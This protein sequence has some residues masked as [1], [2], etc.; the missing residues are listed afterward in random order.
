VLDLYDDFLLDSKIRPFFEYID[1]DEKYVPDV[2]LFNE[3]AQIMRESDDLDLTVKN[4][5]KSNLKTS[6]SVHELLPFPLGI[7][8]EDMEDILTDDDFYAEYIL[9][10]DF[11]SDIKNNAHYKKRMHDYAIDSNVSWYVSENIPYM[12]SIF[13]GKVLFIA[14]DGRLK[15]AL[16]CNNDP[17]REWA[18]KIYDEIKESADELEIEHS[19]GD[20]NISRCE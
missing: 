10:A 8:K 4:H 16:E 12:M 14:D 7:R 5:Y 11:L 19:N 9:S 20:V 18:N 15:L 3:E 17:I 6:D 1:C 13:D 2:D